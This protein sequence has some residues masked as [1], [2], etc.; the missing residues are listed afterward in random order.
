MLVI[1]IILISL[2]CLTSVSASDSNS[3]DLGDFE[4]NSIEVNEVA[5]S[6]ILSSSGNDDVFMSNEES[7]ADENSNDENDLEEEPVASTDKK[8][9]SE[10]STHLE[11]DNDADKENVKVGDS[12]TWILEA[13]NLG[14]NLAKNVQVYDQLPDG[15][16]FVKYSATKGTFDFKTGIWDVG[17]LESGETAILK[18]VTKALTLGEKINKA[19]LTS[20]TISTDPDEC[21]EEEEIDVFAET[22][23]KVEPKYVSLLSYPTGNPIAV[24]LVS[25]LALFAAGI[26]RRY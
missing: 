6:N 17:D 23:A 5:D 9:E 12:V 3:L 10:D 19:N 8:T 1:L 4:D 16:K 7:G 21:Y 11:L 18:I 2:L 14:P 26:R 22:S 24:L 25:T 20:D 15:L 13:K